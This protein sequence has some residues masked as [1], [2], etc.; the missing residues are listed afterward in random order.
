MIDLIDVALWQGPSGNKPAINW[1]R[2]KAAGVQA[3]QI[4]TNLGLIQDKNAILNLVEAHRVG[5]PKGVGAYYA[6][7]L[8]DDPLKQAELLISTVEKASAQVGSGIVTLVPWQD[9]EIVGPFTKIESACRYEIA[10]RR[11]DREY[12][13]AGT[14]SAIYTRMELW[15]K[16]AYPFAPWAGDFPLI[17]ARYNFSAPPWGNPGDASG[18]GPTDWEDWVSHQYTEEGSVDGI[19]GFVDIHRVKDWETLTL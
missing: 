11:L 10:I 4:R 8:S 7:R 1:D 18:V 14:H 5:L 3:V 13:L 6:H 15:R 12:C 19:K 17:V 9:N 2:V 16:L